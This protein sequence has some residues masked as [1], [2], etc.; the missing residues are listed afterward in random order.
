MTSD[1]L[2]VLTAGNAED[3]LS[4][5]RESLPDVMLLDIMLPEKTGLEIAQAIREIDPKLPVIFIT[6]SN[7]SDLAI[8]AMKL[9]A[10][11]ILLKP[12]DVGQLH[13]LV[14]R[15][16]E[17]RRLMH[18]PVVLQETETV[19]QD[20]D[21][22]VGR[23]PAML[24][25]YKQ[26]GRVAAQ[27]VTVLIR[28]ESG[29]G[30]EL[31]ARAIYQHS[32]RSGQCYLAVNC[33][34]LSDTLL[35]S[36]LFGHEKGAFTGADRKHIG[37]FEQCNGGS[38]FLDE[39]GDM[40]P[41]TQGKVLRLMQEQ[42]F[43]R[44]GGSETIK[45]D[46]RMIAATNRPLEEMI[47]D[48]EFRLDLYHRLNTFEIHLPPLRERGNDIEL[49]A[50]HFLSILNRKMGKEIR[51]LSDSAMEILRNHDWP[52]NIRELQ[53]VLR[54]S[55]LMAT[56]PVI[57]PEF[58]PQEI[59]N[60]DSPGTG[61]RA[62]SNGIADEI[63]IQSLVE[64]SLE[65]SSTSLYADTLEKMESYVIQRVL[66]FHDGNQSRAAESLGITRGSLRN[67]IKTLGIVIEKSVV[68]SSGSE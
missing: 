25:V 54:K 5:L 12:L 31:V 4:K 6:A 13:S 35:E 45:T 51:G 49:L 15:A 55:I 28:G 63:G 19:P 66:Q 33:A 29:T 40:S 18:S 39:V 10:Y 27:D 16:I 48:S 61:G 3:G 22:M 41:L 9:G 23:S 2:L 8:E 37:K 20:G 21:A 44:V 32:H 34:A 11:E 42:K 68:A 52:G 30:K 26:I 65:Q 36:E 56:G 60:G 24:E 46:V 59:V 14:E 50:N 62:V 53:S 47:E 67:K 38:I 58:L 7:D 1:E 43:E 64:K 17:T 57:V